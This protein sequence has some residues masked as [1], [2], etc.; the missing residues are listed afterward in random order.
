MAE[1]NRLLEITSIIEDDFVL[2]DVLRRDELILEPGDEHEKRILEKMK[3]LILPKE[4][5]VI[6]SGT[7]PIYIYAKLFR[8]YKEEPNKKIK[9]FACFDPRL[10]GVIIDRNG[11][12]MPIKKEDIIDIDRIIQLKES[13]KK[14][15]LNFNNVRFQIS[16]GSNKNNG[17]LKF[18]LI[19]EGFTNFQ[20]LDIC[21]TGGK[22][23]FA[24]EKEI[25]DKL[26]EVKDFDLNRGVIVSGGAPIWLYLFIYKY[27]KKKKIRSI[28]FD[29][30]ASEP[31]LIEPENEYWIKKLKDDWAEYIEQ[32]PIIENQKIIAIFGP[33]NS[34]KTVFLF[35]LI[36]K[37][38][39]ENV[40]CDRIKGCP[41]GEGHWTNEADQ[42]IAYT[43]RNK[44]KYNDE[45][46]NKVIR[47][48]KYAKR[49]K[50]YLFIDC[51]GKAD[52]Y[53][54]RIAENCT[55]IIIVT[56]S[57]E[58]RILREW[59]SI[60]KEPTRVL[61]EV[62][63]RKENIINPE[64]IV[65]NGIMKFEMLGLERGKEEDLK[66]PEKFLKIFK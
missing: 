11:D 28:V 30:I 31:V 49:R 2:F 46:V 42:K 34:G 62:F 36:N 22:I 8:I 13:Q 47:N 41:D 27:L 40:G 48:I 58:D 32:I 65:D 6:I 50:K 51:G 45:F 29:Y 25:I 21:I 19:T 17:Q 12:N 59:Y 43:I 38:R 20:K 1:T 14:E 26:E 53:N 5:G 44:G 39:K 54:R 66:F 24:G 33:P 61:A 10:G 52:D 15:S 4:C 18:K 35:G 37:L 57:R 55:D 64:V 56:N 60:I 7:L 3:E 63:S 16:N 23:A 9:Y